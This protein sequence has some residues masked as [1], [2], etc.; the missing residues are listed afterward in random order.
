[1]FS[2]QGSR[3]EAFKRKI[4]SFCKTQ[5]HNQGGFRVSSR[6]TSV[7]GFVPGPSFSSYSSRLATRSRPPPGCS[8][9]PAKTALRWCHSGGPALS[10]C[11]GSPARLFPPLLAAWGVWSPFHLAGPREWGEWTKSRKKEHNTHSGLD[12]LE[13]PHHY[14]QWHTVIY[15]F[16]FFFWGGVTVTLGLHM[17]MYHHVNVQSRSPF[18]RWVLF[19]SGE[20]QPHCCSWYWTQRTGSH[21]CLQPT[22]PR[23]QYS[24]VTKANFFLCKH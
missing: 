16:L 17:L 14:C 10:F 5:G 6:T 1:M 15:I 18:P 22:F 19:P 8:G 24:S 9:A 11:C 7:V 21:F 3:V 20:Q 4:K 2:H 13:F 12:L 23:G